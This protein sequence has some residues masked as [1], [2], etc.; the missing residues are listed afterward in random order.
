MKPFLK[1]LIWVA[2][3]PLLIIGGLTY[4]ISAAAV[5]GMKRL[6]DW[7]WQLED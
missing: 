6:D 3:I 2:W 1:L 4:G 5:K 7:Y